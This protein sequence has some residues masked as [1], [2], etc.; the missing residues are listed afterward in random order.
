MRKKLKEECYITMGQSPKGDTYN[1]EN[2]GTPFLQGRRTFGRMYP[3]VDTWT[4]NPI[5]IAKKDSVLM[6]V[7][8]PVGDMNIANR[9]LC[10]GRGLCSLEMKN[11]NN[12]YLYYLLQNNIDKLKGK[13]SG[14]VFDSVNSIDIENLE[15][16]FHNE[17]QQKKIGRTLFNIDKKIE[18]NNEIIDN[19]QKLSQEL[20]K[21]WFVDFEFPNGEGKP[22]KS[23]GGEM[24]ESE[25]GEIPKGW[26]I[27]NFDDGVLTKII[28]SGVDSYQ[29]EKRY[30][31]TADVDGAKIN[32]FSKLKY[33]EKPSRANMTPIKNS[34]WFAK[35]KGSIKNILVEEYMEEIINNY[36]FSTGFL[37]IECLNKSTSYIWNIINEDKFI[38]DKDNLSTGTLMA[39]IS[40]GTIVNFKY[41]IPK[42]KLLLKYEVLVGSLNKNIYFLNRENSYLINLRDT[43]LPK[44]LNGEI[45]I[46]SVEV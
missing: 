29:G 25:L 27:G 42:E 19:F 36:I 16:D 2:M 31:A 13:S 23:S 21:R 34:V 46:S 3:I 22:Y 18:L 45:N 15:L 32:N 38:S 8:A 9:I 7:R 12:I 26:K 43:L 17:D 4:T 6:S 10:I 20:Y 40:N 30:V 35:M 1:F 11:G 28:K 37:G 5:R 44:L 24:I 33:S 39:G 41:L 14:T